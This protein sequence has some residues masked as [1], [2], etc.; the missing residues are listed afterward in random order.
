MEVAKSW[1]QPLCVDTIRETISSLMWGIS[2]R[3]INKLNSI[4]S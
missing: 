3:H 1:L 4:P 2:T